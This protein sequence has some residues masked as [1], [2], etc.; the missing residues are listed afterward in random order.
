MFELAPC[1]VCGKQPK[2]RSRER[3]SGASY[4]KIFCTPILEKPHL[5]SIL[6]SG[7]RH[8]DNSDFLR[9]A[10]TWNEKV[11]TYAKSME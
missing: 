10:Q 2:I 3:L 7:L 5:E 8:V 9:A 4:I 6:Y 1:P 11:K